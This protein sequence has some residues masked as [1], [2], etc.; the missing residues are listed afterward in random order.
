MSILRDAR[1]NHV[2]YAACKRLGHLW[3][4]VRCSA[5][6]AIRDDY[7]SPFQAPSTH[8]GGVPIGYMTPLMAH[9]ADAQRPNEDDP[10]ARKHRPNWLRRP[11][12]SMRCRDCRHEDDLRRTERRREVA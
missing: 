10:C 8:R 9:G 3:G 4:P 1:T 7:T 2:A 12:G 11:D 6:G 5:C